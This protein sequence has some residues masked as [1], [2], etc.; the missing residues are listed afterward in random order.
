MFIIGKMTSVHYKILEKSGI[1]FTQKISNKSAYLSSKPVYT[2]FACEHGDKGLQEIFDEINN[3]GSSVMVTSKAELLYGIKYA[4]EN[5]WDIALIFDN[6]DGYLYGQNVNELGINDIISCNTHLLNNENLNI[7][8][9]TQLYAKKVVKSFLEI[10]G[11]I[12]LTTDIYNE[13]IKNYYKNMK[14]DNKV[15]YNKLY[16]SFILIFIRKRKKKSQ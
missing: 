14:K 7:I 8:S 1:Y 15:V 16:L 6:I 13:F 10:P 12:L 4:S 5:N 9:T 2:I 11:K 3:V